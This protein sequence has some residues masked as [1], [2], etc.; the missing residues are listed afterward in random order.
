MTP[1]TIHPSKE[2]F[3]ALTPGLDMLS[4]SEIE[5]RLIRARKPWEGRSSM[6]EPWIELLEKEQRQV[7]D[8][9]SNAYRCA[10]FKEGTV[11][12]DNQRSH[13]MSDNGIPSID[14]LSYAELCV[15]RDDLKEKQE[16]M[17]GMSKEK[18]SN[19][20]IICVISERLESVS[21]AIQAFEKVTFKQL[22]QVGVAGAQYVRNGANV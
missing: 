15:E 7:I 4:A 21:R 10:K 19:R 13:T 18:I 16:H 12:I 6:V 20:L 14:D 2:Y 8:R 5:D 11:V 17:R 9:L 3:E 1:G 22:K